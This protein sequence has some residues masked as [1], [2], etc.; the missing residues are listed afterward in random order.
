MTM[1]SDDTPVS[2]LTLGELRAF[3]LQ[4]IR[5][6]LEDVAPDDDPRPMSEEVL[7]RLRHYRTHSPQRLSLDEVK[8]ALDMD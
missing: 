5:E 2:Q 4:L 1:L 3:I 6:A 7:A 8:R